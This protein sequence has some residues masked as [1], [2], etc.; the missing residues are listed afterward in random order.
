MPNDT[1]VKPKPL[2]KAQLASRLAADAG[3]TAAQAKDVLDALAATVASELKREG[4]TTF[5]IPDICRLQLV[6][7]AA[8]PAKKMISPFTKLEIEVKA[9]PATNTVRIRP[10]KAIKDAVA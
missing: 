10:V 5:T 7:K 3:L 4:I 9:K 8:T 6:K 2:T 1:A